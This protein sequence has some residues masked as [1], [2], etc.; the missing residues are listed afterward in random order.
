MKSDLSMPRWG[1]PLVMLPGGYLLFR[2]I[3]G[4]RRVIAPDVCYLWADP[5]R[6]E[7]GA[8][9]QPVC[10]AMRRGR[11]PLGRAAIR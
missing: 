5:A 8:L 10:G 4:L 2:C 3:G 11:P 1:A 9:P 7:A 6:A